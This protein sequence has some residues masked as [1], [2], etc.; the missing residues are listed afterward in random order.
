MSDIERLREIIE[1]SESIVFF[2]GA[3]VSTESGIPDFRGTGGLFNDYE[4]DDMT[5][6]EKLH[7]SY[8]RTNPEGFFRYYKSNMIY[9][10]ATPNDAHLF[11]ARLEA[12]GKLRAVVTQN[13]D[14]L[15]TVAGSKCV[16][17]L[18]GS[19]HRNYCM[20][21][22]K[23]YTLDYILEGELVPRCED[24]GGIVRPD[25]TLY[26]EGLPQDAW[27]LAEEAI[28]EA[29]TLIVAGTSLRV[30]PAA[31]LVEGFQGEHLIIINRDP[32]H[33]DAEAEIVINEPIAKTLAKLM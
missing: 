32:T 17:E 7:I 33:M 4:E 5:P 18:H 13:I 20:K 12:E 30:Y 26:G 23:S 16:A 6:E 19:I 22:G 3:G 14:G 2:G 11:L 15:H 25:V 31:S 29:Q 28:Y 8:L 10:D 27:F 1:E 24:C 9:R 21:C